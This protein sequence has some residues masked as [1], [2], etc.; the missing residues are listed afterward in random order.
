MEAIPLVME[1]ESRLYVDPVIVLDLSVLGSCQVHAH[2]VHIVAELPLCDG[3]G[4]LVVP[5][6]GCN[7]GAHNRCLPAP[8]VVH[9]P[10]IDARQEICA[11]AG[12]AHLAC[13]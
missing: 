9:T 4:P 7:L 13:G 10:V 6:E 2:L 11:Q 3:P 5:L 8:I 1:P 12:A